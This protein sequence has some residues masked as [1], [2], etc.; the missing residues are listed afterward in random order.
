MDSICAFNRGSTKALVSGCGD[1]FR[2]WNQ[3]KLGEF[4]LKSY[5]NKAHKKG[6]SF[7]TSIGANGIDIATAG[8]DGLIKLWNMEKGICVT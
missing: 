5:N 6:I 8:K 3:K 7:V 2:I 1:G 4:K